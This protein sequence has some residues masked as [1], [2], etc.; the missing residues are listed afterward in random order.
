MS[1][2]GEMMGHE[3]ILD[4]RDLNA[5]EHALLKSLLTRSPRAGG[6]S[7]QLNDV[8]ILAS[9]GCGC[10]RT[11]FLGL[12]DQKAPTTGVTTII[13][14]ATGQSPEGVRVEV[15][16]H[17]REGKLSELELYAPDGTERF[18]LPSAEALKDVF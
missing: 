16:L 18:T 13:A 5:A 9:C 6:F 14:D 2:D 7:T 4:R 3:L 1:L 8:K 17:V 11:I 10:P 15:I 12:G